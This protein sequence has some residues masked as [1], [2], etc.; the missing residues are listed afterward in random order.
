MEDAFSLIRTNL[1]GIYPMLEYRSTLASMAS[2]MESINQRAARV[3]E[4]H[5]LVD[6]LI[7]TT[8]RFSVELTSSDSII[9]HCEGSTDTAA[10]LDSMF[11]KSLL[12]EETEDAPSYPGRPGF[13]KN[14]TVQ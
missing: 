13:S 1:A 4:M 10:L 3:R 9:V 5:D 2:A 8:Q 14:A 12:S 11:S 7:G 6:K